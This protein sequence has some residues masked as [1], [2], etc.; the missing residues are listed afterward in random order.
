MD[1]SIKRLLEAELKNL[2][3][4]SVFSIQDFSVQLSKK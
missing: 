2:A 3:A 4:G 1:E